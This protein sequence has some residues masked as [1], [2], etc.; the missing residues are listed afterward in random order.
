MLPCYHVFL[1]SSKVH[2]LFKSLYHNIPC[3]HTSLY[4]LNEWLSQV[5]QLHCVCIMNHGLVNIA[6]QWYNVIWVTYH[7]WFNVIWVTCHPWYN[8]IWV[9]CYP[10]Y[11]VIWVTCHPWYTVIWVTCH[12]WY[13]VIW[14]TC[15]PWYTVI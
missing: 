13:T 1:N 6:N 12:P 14:V 2:S 8:V 10:W 4:L 9:T 3:I 11:K 5:R 15:H 7:P